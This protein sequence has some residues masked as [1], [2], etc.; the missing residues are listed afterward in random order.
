MDADKANEYV[1]KA[2]K[3]LIECFMDSPT[4]YLEEK[5]L[6]NEFDRILRR[7]IPENKQ[8]ALAESGIKGFPS[9]PFPVLM[10][11]YATVYRYKSSE[12][13]KAW[14][15]DEG[16]TGSL[17]YVILDPEWINKI[18]YNTAVNKD[19]TTRKKV[20]DNKENVL[21]PNRFLVTIEFKYLH[22]G[23][24][25]KSWNINKNFPSDKSKNSA[26]DTIIKELKRDINKQLNESPP[27][28]HAVYFNSKI[29]LKEEDIKIIQDKIQEHIKNKSD[30]SN[31]LKIWYAQGGVSWRFG[32]DA[33]LSYILY[34][35]FEQIL[36]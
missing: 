23:E 30:Y 24:L 21:S 5:H 7:I 32:K 20:R 17:D 15:P 36:K 11:E 13:F 33:H 18:N 31:N 10:N 12:D 14:Y 22:Y 34:P 3:K 26:I 35:K 28:A 25:K 8:T 9:V 6:H 1:E 29:N 4:I 16:N 2:I 19:E 27:Y